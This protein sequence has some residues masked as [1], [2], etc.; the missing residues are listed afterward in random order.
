VSAN[1]FERTLRKV[2]DPLR[3]ETRKIRKTLL[4]WSLVSSAV[5]I[6]GLF[7]NEVSAL[8]L[9]VAPTSKA[10]LF[11]LIAA[12]VLYHLVA[13]VAYAASD[14]A[15]WYLD[16]KSTEWEDDVANYEKHKSELLA[17]TKLSAE[18]REFMEEHERRLGSLWRGES[19]GTYVRLESAVPYISLLRAIVEFL[20][21]LV[22][23]LCAFDLLVAASRNAA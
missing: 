2:S 17:H 9:K 11:G 15:R 3:E 8:G 10:V 20:L 16:L 22:V 19:S 6:G 12:V 21:P 18:D 5:T 1:P 7:P 13:F 23:G 4:V 14:A